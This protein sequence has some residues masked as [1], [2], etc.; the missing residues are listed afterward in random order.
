MTS[1]FPSSM[2]IPSKKRELIKFPVPVYAS[3]LIVNI[4]GFWSDGQT[5]GVTIKSY[6]L[7]KSKS[8]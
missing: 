8:R 2:V 3:S 5:T 1:D 6:F 7:A 4:S